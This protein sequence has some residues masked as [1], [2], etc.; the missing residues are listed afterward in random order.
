MSKYI[1]ASL[2]VE[3]QIYDEGYEEWSIQ[4]G[5]IE[6]LLNQWTEEG[7][8]P[9]IEVSEDCIGRVDLIES[10]LA[11]NECEREE[12]KAC[13]CSLDLMLE[14]IEDAPPTTPTKRTTETMI[15]DGEETEIDPVSYEIG[16]THGQTAPIERTGEWVRKQVTV[17]DIQFTGEE[18]SNC[19][20]WKNMG[21]WNYCPN[22][23]AKM[24]NVD[25]RGKE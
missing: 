14:L 16:Y 10:L 2:F 9:P 1:D 3:M 12:A 15:V 24:V 17:D 11:D 19:N 4:N 22:C 21:T 20:F 5:T 8:P 23:G 25:M 7:C 6:D 18:C 13:M